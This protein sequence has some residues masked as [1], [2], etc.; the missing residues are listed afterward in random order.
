MN[1]LNYK[2]NPKRIKKDRILSIISLSFSTIMLIKSIADE[3]IF[4]IVLFSFFALAGIYLTL[5]AFKNSNTVKVNKDGI[6]NKTNSMGLI[7]WKFIT[8][9]EILTAMG[10]QF[11]VIKIN[12]H[13]KLLNEMSRFARTLMK[14]NIKKFGSPVIIA[15]NEFNESLDEVKTKLQEYKETISI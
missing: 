4:G 12:D 1:D 7:E 3:S 10:N 15:S 9:F 8:D 13:E 6:F 5:K 11:L 2:K 14:T